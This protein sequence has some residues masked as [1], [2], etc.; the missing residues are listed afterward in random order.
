MA[1]DEIAKRFTLH[2]VF[3]YLFPGTLTVAGFG[4]CMVLHEAHTSVQARALFSAFKELHT[5]TQGAIGVSVAYFVGLACVSVG[6]LALRV[7]VWKFVSKDANGFPRIEA[8]DGKRDWKLQEC[9]LELFKE[10]LHKEMDCKRDFSNRSQI[11]LAY[12]YLLDRKRDDFVQIMA[13]RE[14]T[15]KSLTGASLLTCLFAGWLSYYYKLPSPTLLT[16]YALLPVI[17][18]WG[19]FSSRQFE[20]WW[21]HHV[22]YCF[23][24]SQNSADD[25]RKS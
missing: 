20:R 13:G 4:A 17:L 11:S 22:I 25:A 14:V 15:Y 8:F 19:L 5:V 16:L 6:H 12:A 2:D 1:I 21:T 3:G 9:V 24:M 7:Y 18:L 10:K 23:L